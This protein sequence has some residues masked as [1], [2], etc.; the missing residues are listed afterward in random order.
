MAGKVNTKF[1]V[2]LSA[3]L[4]LVFGLL[5]WAFVALAFKS[6]GDFERMGDQ[7][8]A[9]GDYFRAQRMYGRAV[10]KDTTNRVW[11]DKWIDA[12]E[13]WTPET[14]TAYLNA[15]GRE[16]IGAIN[17]LA[18]AERTD[19]AAHE[20]LLSLLYERLMYGYSRQQADQLV[21]LATTAAG[22]FDRSDGSDGWKRLLRYRG[23]AMEMVMQSG[24][25]VTDDQ[26]ALIGEDLRA[27]LEADPGDG[28]AAASL[29]RWHVLK[30]RRGSTIDQEQ[31][32][33]RG[34]A[35]AL[36]IADE[37]RADNPGDPH[38]ELGRLAL[39]LEQNLAQTRPGETPS[40][41]MERQRAELSGYRD[42]LEGIAGAIAELGP[43]GVDRILLNRFRQMDRFVNSDEPLV[44]TRR[45]L[46]DLLAQRPDE[47]T[48]LEMSAEVARQRE[49]LEKASEIYERIVGL[50]MLPLSLDGVLR[51]RAQLEA[52]RQRSMVLLDLHEVSRSS[53]SGVDPSYLDEAKAMRERYRQQVS[54]D[55]FGL[56]L[57][58]GRVAVAEGNDTEALRIFRRHNEM[59]Q[60]RSTEGLWLEATT[61][62]RLDR[63]G[64]AATALRALIDADRNNIRALMLLAQIERQLQNNAQAAELLRRALELAPGYE[65]AREQLRAIEMAEN[66]DLIEDPVI[67]LLTRARR[68]NTGAG[69]AAPD[70]AAAA[71]LIEQNIESVGY[72]PR[73]V[74]DLVDLRVRM[75]DM[76]G[77]RAVVERA[78][79]EH[80]DSEQLRTMAEALTSPDLPTARIRMIEMSD[81]G[82][83]EKTLAIASIAQSAGLEDRLDEALSTL[84]RIAPEDPGYLDIAFI[85]SL[86]RG[87]MDEA[88]R[89]A[90]RAE[91]LDAD[92]V[93]GLTYRARVASVAGE[94]AR[95]VEALEQAVALG[96]GGES[97]HR[98]LGR[99]LMAVGRTQDAIRAYE[100]ALQIRPDNVQATVEYIQALANSGQLGR[101]L[102]EARERRRYGVG[103]PE[104]IELW[105][106]LEAA[107]GGDEGVALAIGQRERM[108][109]VN[110]ANRVNRAA[111]A[112]LYIGESRWDEARALIDQ[113]RAEADSLGLAVL[114][115]RWYAEQG[116]VG[117]RDGLVLAQQAFD[118]YIEGLGDSEEAV[119]ANIAMAQFM[120]GRGRPDLALRAAEDAVAR[121]SSRMRGTKLRGEI[122]MD[123]G[124]ASMAAD[125]FR[126]V[127]EGGADTEEH[128]YRTRLIEV[129]VRADRLDEA[130]AQMELLPEDRRTSLTGML[131]R[132]DI[133]SRKG[134]KEA[135][136]RIL[137][138]A[139]AA[140]PQQPLVYVRRAQATMYEPRLRSDTLADLET[141]LRLNPGDWRALRVR[142]AV[143]LSADR[144]ADALRDLEAA[145]RSNPSDN[146]LLFS[147]ANELLDDGRPGEAFDA[148]LRVLEIRSND[149]G[150]MFELGRLFEQRELW[151]RA[152]EMY[153]RAWRTRRGPND[154]I[155]YIDTLLRS[156]PPDATRASEVFA[157]L[158]Q[159][160]GE[161]A[162]AN[163]GLLAI[164]AL[165]L[166]ARGREELALQQMTRAFELALSDENQI[167]GW[168]ANA[169]RF[170]LNMTPQSELNYYRTLRARYTDPGPSAW[171]DMLIA[172]RRIVHGQ[173]VAE[174]LSDLERLGTSDQAPVRARRMALRTVGNHRFE[175]G[176]YEGA[177][178]AWRAGLDAAPDDWELN[179]NIAYVLS[180]RLGRHEEA[181]DMAEP[182]LEASGGQPEVYD[183]MASVY[184]GLG[185]LDEAE[186]MLD[187]AEPRSRTYQSRAALM[188]TR[189]RLAIAR[190]DRAEARRRLDD[191]RAVLRG[192]AGHDGKT[193]Q[194]I[195]ELEAEIGSEG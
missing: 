180:T 193:E 1:V 57:L 176:D 88:R 167:L 68:I 190:E 175:R 112:E 129:L 100:R 75:G 41:R 174:A 178:D 90:G 15:F 13:S 163:P 93:R 116:R 102:Q 17:Q 48:L 140:H 29:M 61:A 30:E 82:D 158:Q 115:A 192:S 131:Q 2:V 191:A 117:A 162:D 166:R 40:E 134:D 130:E 110:P 133:A 124:K 21:D 195:R 144:R 70:T 101:A 152:S 104:F 43:D 120:L 60:N 4:V 62:Y 85:R 168:A 55:D 63:T 67:S 38:L 9:E 76:A 31:A 10:G 151:G 107:E 150:L 28:E 47:A 71:A 45:L 53:A 96:T 148:A 128:T 160:A 46:D 183:T 182:A 157:S 78:R 139:A 189:A 22:Y 69:G 149:A 37:F 80:P 119:D 81:L 20:R 187:M 138:E 65:V 108:L 49:D 92:R 58:D 52:M 5:A 179:N 6:G 123:L 64:T 113:L 105:L 181:L 103:L 186:Q 74:G 142:A 156:S 91:S 153:G 125:A 16:Y 118:S 33:A 114:E 36:R 188:I 77:A 127:V 145:L 147:L 24:S 169:Q 73:V 50:P 155:R 18:A 111:L 177:I 44:M 161:N 141:A 159:M 14:Q 79:R 136:R 86:Q 126:E 184:I 170:Y 27:A 8:M 59:T 25:V 83:T 106:R 23:L 42:E 19:V 34:R 165:V 99:E 3:G 84:E 185:R 66:P 94:N 146:T 172:Q 98:L 171:L 132:A 89:L 95:A 97:V 109:E 32:V 7:A 135:E 35:E 12:M 122:L 72:D 56:M 154:A 143:Y 121:Q 11:L 87:D 137:D 54:E 39:L 51:F 173:D 26:V 194:V 164:Q